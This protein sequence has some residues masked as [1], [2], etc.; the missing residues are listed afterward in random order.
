MI[1]VPSEVYV[2][3]S[4]FGLTLDDIGDQSWMEPVSGI[5][6]LMRPAGVRFPVLEFKVE[7][8]KSKEIR[9]KCSEMGRSQRWSLLK[10]ARMN[11]RGLKM[12]FVRMK[13][14]VGFQRFY[15]NLYDGMRLLHR[16][17]FDKKI[18]VVED[19][20]NVLIQAVAYSFAE[21]KLGLEKVLAETEIR[22]K[23]VDWLSGLT[24]N[25]E[26]EERTK[27]REDAPALPGWKKRVGVK[28]SR[29][30]SGS[31]PNRA[32]RLKLRVLKTAEEASGRAPSLPAPGV[33]GAGNQRGDL[34]NGPQQEEEMEDVVILEE[35]DEVLRE[36]PGLSS[37]GSVLETE[38]SKSLPPEPRKKRV[39]SAFWRSSAA[40]P[41]ILSYDEMIEIPGMAFPDELE[42]EFEIPSE[43]MDF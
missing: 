38:E 17:I 13:R 29:S 8:S 20:K 18:D 26:F 41:R 43:E 32:K 34:V 9:K 11:P 42:F 22:R 12:F 15:R 2:I 36:T 27:W 19:V 28:R 25:W 7:S 10:W 6:G 30:Q 21:E 16:R 31:K 4:R 24:S 33:P 39:S 37:R 1:R 35:D 3:Y 40:K 14:E 23:R 5:R